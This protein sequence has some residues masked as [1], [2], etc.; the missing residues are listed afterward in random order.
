[1][2]FGKTSHTVNCASGLKNPCSKCQ[3]YDHD[4]QQHCPMEFQGETSEA[5]FPINLQEG[6][7]HIDLAHPLLSKATETEINQSLQARAVR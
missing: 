1:V 7:N 6:P 3:T 4:L 5:T 2:N